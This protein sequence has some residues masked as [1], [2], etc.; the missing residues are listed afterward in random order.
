MIRGTI[1]RTGGLIMRYGPFVP[2][3]DLR[4]HVLPTKHCHVC[5]ATYVVITVYQRDS[6]SKRPRLSVVSAARPR[7]CTRDTRWWTRHPGLRARRAAPPAPLETAPTTWS[8]AT[9]PAS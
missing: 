1:A 6:S 8:E 7:S 9:M 5:A 4:L 2:T 3:R